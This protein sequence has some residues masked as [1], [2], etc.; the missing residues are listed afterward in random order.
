MSEAAT[1]LLPPL[2]LDEP[3]RRLPWVVLS[4]LC[5][6]LGVLG[7]FALLLHAPAQPPAVFLPLDAQLIE[8]PVQG[9]SAPAVAP[10][11]VPTPPVAAP[12]RARPQPVTPPVPPPPKKVLTKPRALAA[13][14]PSPPAHESEQLSEPAAGPATTAPSNAPSPEAAASVAKS[15]EGGGGAGGGAGSGSGIGTGSTGARA[16]YAPVP[17]IPDDLRQNIFETFAMA[18]FQITA[19]GRTDV[20]LT[21]PTS[22]P[23]LNQVLLAALKQWRFFPAIREGKP[24]DSEFEVRIPIVVR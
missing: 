1:R 22:N 6:W 20:T 12:Q 14:P 23:R 19:D 7:G 9:G 2:A 18:R 5:C 8:L 21:T 3:W 4:A 24:I 10:E 17:S 15:T 16:I 11:Q 13:V